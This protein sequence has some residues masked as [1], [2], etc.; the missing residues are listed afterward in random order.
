[1]EHQYR[2]Y[3]M[4]SLSGTLYIGVTSD[5]K[6]GHPP[7]PPT[8]L[9]SAYFLHVATRVST[10]KISEPSRASPGRRRICAVGV[11]VELPGRPKARRLSMAPTL[12]GWSCSDRR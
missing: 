8:L 6:V 9:H 7:S 1:M 12:S 11:A 3:I 4:S 10:F 2:A 5:G